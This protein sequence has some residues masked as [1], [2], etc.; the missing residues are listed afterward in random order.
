[1]KDKHYYVS[2]HVRFLHLK[3]AKKKKMFFP[4]GDYKMEI[5]NK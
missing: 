5:F 3:G 2:I 1:M 4:Q